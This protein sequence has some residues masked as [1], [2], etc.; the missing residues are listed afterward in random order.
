MSILIANM[1]SVDASGDGRLSVAGLRFWQAL[2]GK[3]RPGLGSLVLEPAYFALPAT[4]RQVLA[5]FERFLTLA[6]SGD[7][8]AFEHEAAR[9]GPRSFRGLRYL[10]LC[11]VLPELSV[12]AVR[13][14]QAEQEA[15]RALRA[16]RAFTERQAAVRVAG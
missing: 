3:A 4:R 14:A 10:P 12:A 1:Y 15:Q 16:L 2:H 8:G 7:A 5:E 13:A 9:Y 6:R 11:K